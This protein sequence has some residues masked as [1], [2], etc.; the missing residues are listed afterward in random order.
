MSVRLAPGQVP[1]G[2]IWLSCSQMQCPELVMKVPCVLPGSVGF[3]HNKELALLS[4]NFP[5]LSPSGK[6]M[7]NVL[8]VALLVI[9][10]VRCPACQGKLHSHSQMPLSKPSP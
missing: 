8:V 3:F 7:K 10:Q 4:Y 6:P 2:T 1:Q 5:T 9:F